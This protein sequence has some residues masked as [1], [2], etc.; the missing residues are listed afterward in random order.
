MTADV[1]LRAPASAPAP[2]LRWALRERR[3]SLALWGIALAAVA[4]MYMA[5]YP[6]M[7]NEDMEALIAGLPEAL[8]VGMGWD[9]ISSGAGYLESTV[10]GLLAPALLLVFAVSHG[11][12]LVAGEE[13]GGTLELESTAPVSR[14]GLVLQRFGALVLC[15]AVLVAVLTVVTLLLVPALD[16]GVSAGGVLAAAL[17]LWLFVVAMG[18]VTFAVGAAT[19]RRGTAL[20][21]GSGVAVASYMAHALAPMAA[22]AGWLADVSPFAWYLGGD[23]LVEGVSAG[24]YSGLVALVVLAVVGAVVSFGRRDLGV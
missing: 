10:Y 20:A 24:G 12:R 22:G 19:G 3:R 1:V 15:V 9:R 7:A 6:S 4:A 14:R 21:V 8:R 5:F 18:A 11:A 13:E 23:P 16:M 17:G 2:V